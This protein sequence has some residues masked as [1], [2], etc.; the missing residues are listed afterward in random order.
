MRSTIGK[1]TRGLFPSYYCG[2]YA[3]YGKDNPTGC[4][5]HR[6]RHATLETIVTNYVEQTAPKVAEL[7]RATEVGDLE[8]ARPLLQAVRT[9]SRRSCRFATRHNAVC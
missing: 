9:P 4:R 2:N 1:G 7:L 6:V 8:A 5:C 3:T